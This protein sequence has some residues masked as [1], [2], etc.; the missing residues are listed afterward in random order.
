MKES[1]QIDAGEPEG[2]GG[3]SMDGAGGTVVR[4]CSLTT[5]HWSGR[6]PRRCSTHR[7]TWRWPVRRPTARRRCAR[8]TN[9]G[10][11]VVLMDIRMPLLDGLAATRRLTDDPD[12]R[13]T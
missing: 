13:R 8:C 6:A 1:R 3:G 2:G 11:D 12:L 5:S 9:F 4:S 7:R 10:P